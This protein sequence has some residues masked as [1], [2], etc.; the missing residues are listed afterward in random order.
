MSTATG[1]ASEV[2]QPSDRMIWDH[3]TESNSNWAEIGSI[4]PRIGCTP[5]TP[6]RWDRRAEADS[7]QGLATIRE[8]TLKC[9]QLWEKGVRPFEN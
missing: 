7:A 1:Y 4:A 9:C 6:R 2:H 3:A 5:K 8:M